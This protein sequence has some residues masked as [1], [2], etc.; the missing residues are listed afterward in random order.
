[1]LIV[2]LDG[3]GLHVTVVITVPRH[4]GQYFS[5]FK[6]FLEIETLSNCHCLDV[7]WSF[8][9]ETILHKVLS[10]MLDVIMQIRGRIFTTIVPIVCKCILSQ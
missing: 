8:Q 6:I 4:F 3:R 5:A 9:V 2:A 1:M 10:F 7:P